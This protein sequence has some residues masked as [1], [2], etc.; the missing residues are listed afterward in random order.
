M[1]SSGFRKICFMGLVALGCAGVGLGC[2]GQIKTA[3][4]AEPTVD[5][6]YAN[7]ITFTY[8]NIK[9][10]YPPG[11]P[12]EST[13][14]TMAAGYVRSMKRV[15]EILGLSPF[16]DTLKIYY[17][18]GFGQGRE[19]TG[20]QYPFADSNAIHFWLPSFYGPTLLQYLLPRWAP[21][22]PRHK[23]LRH[24]LISLF[25][26]SGQNY[27]ASTIGYKNAGELI[28]L[29]KL[30]TDTATNSNEERYQSAEAASFCAFVIGE[31]GPHALRELYLS[32]ASFDSSVIQTC[33]VPVDTLQMRWLAF[34]KMNV[35]KDSIRE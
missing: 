11:H 7:W 19:L 34:V 24:G 4:Q 33:F 3:P 26:F 35:P 23:F 30:A 14:T 18:S 5:S 20:Q 10:I 16:T 8:Q 1:Y 9:I 22:P 2:K 31:F 17:Y 28:P 27:H 6:R 13:F 12:Q 21:D 29:E 25:D 32:P 15:E